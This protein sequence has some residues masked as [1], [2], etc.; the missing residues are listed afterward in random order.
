MPALEVAHPAA[1]ARLEERLF[2]RALQACP[3]ALSIV[4]MRRPEQ[5]LVYVN[6]AFE[7]L[8]GYPRAE[9]LGR[10]CR[11]LRAGSADGVAI[12]RIRRALRNG[13]RLM[14]T[15]RNA[16]KDG[17]EFI[18]ELSLEP[19]FD[20]DGAL[21]HFVGLHSDAGEREGRQD[22]PQASEPRLGQALPGASWAV[23]IDGAGA[24]LCAAVVLG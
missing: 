6:P 24:L 11:F 18:T 7:R 15:M 9:A 23:D 10:N 2:E 5:P 19:L 16:R 14:I 20:G 4:D 3:Q 12:Q 8:T 13:E 21:T 1:A 17:A 22:E